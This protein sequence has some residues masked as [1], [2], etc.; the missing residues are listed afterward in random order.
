ME[1]GRASIGQKAEITKKGTQSYLLIFKGI[2]KRSG[3]EEILTGRGQ[4]PPS[5]LN[6]APTKARSG[7]AL[8]IKDYGLKVRITP[9]SPAGTLQSKASQCFPSVCMH[10]LAVCSS[11]IS[12]TADSRP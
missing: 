4:E 5:P 3:K 1:E 10:I 6:L 7:I 11:V 2:Q 9:T 8:M 12:S